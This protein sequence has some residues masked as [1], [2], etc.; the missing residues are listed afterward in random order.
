MNGNSGN[1]DYIE[2][3]ENI[4]F[5]NEE[6]E[7]TEQKTEET[8]VN[9]EDIADEKIKEVTDKYIRLYAEYE[10]FRKRTAKE[11][12][13]IY[14]NAAADIL[15]NILPVM[16]N[17]ERALQF[18]GDE[19]EKIFEG[20]KMI[21]AQFAAALSNLGVEE[22]KAEGEQFDPALH[23]AVFHEQDENQPDNTVTEVLQKGYIKGDRVLRPATVKVVN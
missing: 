16:D 1:A 10:N 17:F 2:N 19:P 18:S 13:E 9:E 12:S 6:P 22:I 11:K 5:E 20:I 15:K 21:E 7:N 23:N 8:A 4:D 3:I 14:S